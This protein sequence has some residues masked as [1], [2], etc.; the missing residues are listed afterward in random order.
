MRE[1]RLRAAL[2]RAATDPATTVEA[3]MQG[4]LGKSWD[5]ELESFR[6]A[7]DGAP[8]RWLHQVV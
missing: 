7:G 3:E 6:H 4:L 8:V 2:A 1:D 5:D